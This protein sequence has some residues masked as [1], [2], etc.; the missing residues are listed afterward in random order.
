MKEIETII[1]E[2]CLDYNCTADEENYKKMELYKILI[3]HL[4]TK[5]K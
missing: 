5:Q 3:K 4:C 1:K 2:I